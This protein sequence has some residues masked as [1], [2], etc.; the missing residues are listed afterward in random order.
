MTLPILGAV[1]RGGLSCTD[2]MRQLDLHMLR[3]YLRERHGHCLGTYGR[4]FCV[5]RARGLVSRL[6]GRPEC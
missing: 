3:T 2:Y 5:S 4:S 1:H 6:R